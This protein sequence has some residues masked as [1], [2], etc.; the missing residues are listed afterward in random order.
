MIHPFLGL[1]LIAIGVSVLL[2]INVF[3]F[4]LPIGLIL[5]GVA[6]L[7][8]RDKY[9]HGSDE[10][11]KQTEEK[12]TVKNIGDI[13][14]EVYVFSGTK[15]RIQSHGFSEGRVITVFGG[16]DLDLRDVKIPVGR[17]IR[18][19]L[20]A[21]FG[22]IRLQVPENWSVSSSGMSAIFGGFDN[23]ATN[24]S[25]KAVKVFV[26]GASVLAGIDVYY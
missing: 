25:D 23:R 19:E 12:E 20:V 16:A 6:L 13:L 22:G 8:K 1:V 14:D 15:K 26:R 7:T 2:G 5:L 4:I 11:V 18:L 9:A 10:A 21:V 24:D 17:A 3:H